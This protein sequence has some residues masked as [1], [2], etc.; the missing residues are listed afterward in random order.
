MICLRKSQPRDKDPVGAGE[1]SWEPTQ[2]TAEEKL[3]E[4]V[5]AQELLDAISPPEGPRKECASQGQEIR[6]TGSVQSL[7]A[8]PFC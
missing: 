6:D 5:E 4:K 7:V 2:T 1:S 3:S 8:A